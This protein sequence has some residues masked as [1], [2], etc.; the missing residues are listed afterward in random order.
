MSRKGN[1][2]LNDESGAVMEPFFLNLKMERACN[3]DYAHHAE[4]TNDIAD[5]IVGFYNSTRLHLKLGNLSPNAMRVGLRTLV[6]CAE[7]DGDN[8]KTLILRS[9][10][11]NR[12]T[13]LARLKEGNPP[14]LSD[15]SFR[16]FCKFIGF[17]Q[18]QVLTEP[19]TSVTL[20]GF[21][22]NSEN[23]N[24]SLMEVSQTVC[25]ADDRPKTDRFVDN[26]P[27]QVGNT[28]K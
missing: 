28:F 15:R 27:V 18:A 7:D 26:I 1:C 12:L 13:R 4:A 10:H 23:S 16:I 8:T 19:K 5:D 22:R 17:L 20:I 25:K 24:N 9:H 3:K 6:K 14:R 2:W 21:A 11:L